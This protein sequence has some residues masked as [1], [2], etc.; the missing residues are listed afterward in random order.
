MASIKAERK[1]IFSGIWRSSPSA[2]VDR[3]LRII[4]EEFQKKPG[5][6]ASLQLT[7]NGV[8]LHVISDN[9]LAGKNKIVDMCDIFDVTVNKYH[10][11][12]LMV[13]YADSKRVYNFMVC[14]CETELD[15]VD[16]AKSFRECKN[17]LNK[18]NWVLKPKSM[19]NN[20]EGESASVTSREKGDGAE[21]DEARRVKIGDNDE[22]DVLVTS[23][24]SS[25]FDSVMIPDDGSRDDEEDHSKASSSRHADFD[26]DS[27]VSI[28]S[29]NSM[30]DDLLALSQEV[31]N[32]KLLLQQQGIDPEILKQRGAHYNGDGQATPTSPKSNGAD[33]KVNFAVEQD[34]QRKPHYVKNP[35]AQGST[36]T[37][38]SKGPLK[39]TYYR[40]SSSGASGNSVSPGFTG[41]N[42]VFDFPAPAPSNPSSGVGYISQSQRKG[43]QSGLTT[44]VQRPIERVYTLQPRQSHS[45][46][47]KII[48]HP[49]QSSTLPAMRGHPDSGKPLTPIL[50]NG[51]P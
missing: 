51:H 30:K 45:T 6:P 35:H 16:L 41:A 24:D 28:E 26:G 40:T 32:I 1:V 31:R 7:S 42:D 21:H 33:R 19:S 13:V 8:E 47:R 37:K 22:E 23:I 3:Q 38:G 34:S 27:L 9:G 29:Y 11:L 4:G 43:S 5:L 20:N 10:P 49:G 18:P 48:I 14:L 44:T 17:A 12:C 15:G 39:P 36:L 25:G 46:R 50:K 2:D